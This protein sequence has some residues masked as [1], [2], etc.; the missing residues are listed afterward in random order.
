M[1]AAHVDYDRILT[2]HLELKSTMDLFILQCYYYH[3]LLL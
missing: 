2:L 3:K 1:M